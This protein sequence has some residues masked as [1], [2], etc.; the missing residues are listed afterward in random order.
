MNKTPRTVDPE[1]MEALTTGMT[2]KSDK[3]RALAKAGYARAEIARFLDIRY[4]HVRNVLVQ[5][6]ESAAVYETDKP[7]PA[8]VWVT[9]GADGRLALPAEYRAL[10][11]IENGGPVYLQLEDGTLR[12][13]GRMR[14]LKDVQALVARYTG[15]RLSV[16]EFLAERRAEAARE[17]RGE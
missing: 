14:T 7:P 12:M 17:E 10:L 2:T 6:E 9:V 4:Q 1:A 5:A 16:D 8:G 15:G 3:I 13:K 11:E